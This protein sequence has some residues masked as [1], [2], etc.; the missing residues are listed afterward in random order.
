MAAQRPREEEQ[1]RNQNE[2]SNEKASK[3]KETSKIWH[4]EACYTIYKYGSLTCCYKYLYKLICLSF[5]SSTQGGEQR[6][7]TRAGRTRWANGQIV[8]LGGKHAFMDALYAF[9]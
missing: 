1:K 3:Q 6:A 8:K 5:S 4:A 7:W 9:Q 2:D